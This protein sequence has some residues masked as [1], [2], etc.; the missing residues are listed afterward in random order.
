M[1]QNAI[2]R[3]YDEVIAGHYDRDPH[4]V[5]GRSLDR[6]VDQIK[7]QGDD[8]IGGVPLRAL[9]LG[10]GTGA[11]LARLRR[12]TDTL[13]PFGIDLSEKMIEIAQSRLPDLVA[14]VDDAANLEAH[15]ESVEFDLVSTHFVTGFVPIDV[16]APKIHDRLA[17]GGYWSLVGGT[18]AGFPALQTIARGRL[19]RWLYGGPPPDLDEL[20]CNPAGQ[21]EIVASLTTQGF[22][23]RD[24]ETFTPEF[25]FKNLD[26]FLAFA[27]YGGWLTPIVESLGLHKARW[28]TRAVLNT[29]AFPIRDRHSIEI[30]LAQKVAA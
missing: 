8:L 7:G 22:V 5:I 25:E 20:L 4:G 1:L 26:D 17:E 19:G 12:F 11:F 27:Y 13:E 3:Q 23:V 28:T 6:A 18:K 21:E 29:F 10:M 2:Q 9:D 16:L 24:A 30:V 15:F 14:A